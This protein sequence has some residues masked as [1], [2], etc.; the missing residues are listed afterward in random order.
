MKCAAAALLVLAMA[1]AQT[2]PTPDAILVAGASPAQTPATAVVLE[3]LSLALAPDGALFG[4]ANIV[5]LA[6]QQHV[7]RVDPAGILTA[8][9]GPW[10]ASSYP[11]VTALAADAAGDLFVAE[12]IL[13]RIWKLTPQ[14]AVITIAGDGEQTPDGSGAVPANS[15]A[16]VATSLAIDG[17]G[18]IYFSSNTP[19]VW[20]VSPDGTLRPFAGSGLEGV[21]QPTASTPALQYGLIYPGRLAADKAG[22]VYIADASGVLGVTP[23]GML[24]QIL[25]GLNPVVTS[26]AV[27]GLGNLYAGLRDSRQ[28]VSVAPDGSLQALAGGEPTSLDGCTASAPGVP[29]AIHAALGVPSDLA[30]DSAGNL[31]FA[32]PANGRV[33]KITLDGQ[34]HTVAGGPGGSFGGDG[35][36]AEFAELD[37][38]HGAVVGPDGAIYI[39]DTN[40]HRIRKVA[41]GA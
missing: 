34:I 39:G 37:R 19:R 17:L 6:D 23:D 15:V 33:R 11:I 40:N 25:P 36:P 27:D 21:S 12:W 28:I 29:Q 13:H 9:H 35:G 5:Y 31:Y 30:A 3:P 10:E 16:V 32:E 26:L 7:W 1:S 38:P 8:V 41:R 2:P 24:R 22:N 14:G 4:P 20:Q 18:N